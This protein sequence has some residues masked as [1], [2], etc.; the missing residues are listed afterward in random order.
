[1]YDL[2]T[3]KINKELQKPYASAVSFYWKDHAWHFDVMVRK[4]AV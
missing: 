4:S 3:T 2:F 1:M